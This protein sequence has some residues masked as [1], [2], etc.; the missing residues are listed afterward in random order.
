VN[1]KAKAICA[2]RLFQLKYIRDYIHE[3][4]H[5]DADAMLES[6]GIVVNGVINPDC[7][8]ETYRELIDGVWVLEDA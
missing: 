8:R 7:L 2:L 4:G 1:I 6:W 5:N 3:R